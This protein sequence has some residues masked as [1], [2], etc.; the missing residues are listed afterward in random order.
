MGGI[1]RE[2]FHA[3]TRM[4]PEANSTHFEFLKLDKARGLGIAFA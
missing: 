1:F 2:Q 3:L 4:H